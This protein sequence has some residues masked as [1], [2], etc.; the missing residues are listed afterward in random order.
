MEGKFYFVNNKR[1][2]RDKLIVDEQ[3]E[4]ARDVAVHCQIEVD[5]VWIAW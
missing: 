4:L 1:K 3:Y 5:V 2:I